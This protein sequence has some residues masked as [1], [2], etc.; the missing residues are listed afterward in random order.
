MDKL[1]DAINI[2][3]ASRPDEPAIMVFDAALQTALTWQQ[4]QH[5]VRRLVWRL[6]KD[7]VKVLALA[8][9]NA[10][11]WIVADVACAM[12]GITL[13]PLPGFFAPG[14]LQ[15]ALATVPVDAVLYDATLPAGVLDANGA[16]LSAPEPLFGLLYQLIPR[17]EGELPLHCL[18]APARLRLPL[19]PPALRK[20]PA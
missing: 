6:R 15:H 8:A 13:L 10:P 16:K 19:G 9:D 3:A 4:L 12:A 1:W 20:A 2:Q 17:T 5:E 14:Q 7:K 18:R 11:A